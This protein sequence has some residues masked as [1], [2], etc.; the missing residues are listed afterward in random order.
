MFGEHCRLVSCSMKNLFDP[1]I[2]SVSTYVYQYSLV[3]VIVLMSKISCFQ[4]LAIGYLWDTG[5]SAANSFNRGGKNIQVF[6]V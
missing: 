5:D 2:S 1:N 4:G 6:N 3:F